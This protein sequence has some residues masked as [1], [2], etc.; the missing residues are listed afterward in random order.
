MRTVGMFAGFWIP[1]DPAKF[2]N[3]VSFSADF[4]CV[5]SCL[6]VITSAR[7]LPTTALASLSVSQ[8]TPAVP[9]DSTCFCGPPSA[10]LVCLVWG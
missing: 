10:S 8:F 1:V 7:T 5:L 4:V 2:H 9:S 6:W 3:L